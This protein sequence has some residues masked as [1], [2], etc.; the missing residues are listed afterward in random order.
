MDK[1]RKVL[2]NT[3]GGRLVGMEGGDPLLP[4]SPGHHN[5]IN[6]HSST[7]PPFPH[8][9]RSPSPSCFHTSN[10]DPVYLLRFLKVFHFYISHNSRRRE[11]KHLILGYHLFLC[12]AWFLSSWFD[13][14]TA[15]VTMHRHLGTKAVGP[16]QF[17]FLRVHPPGQWVIK[18]SA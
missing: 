2:N 4:D 12:F 18:R 11:R 5:S 8:R 15:I 7:S 14:F 17:N 3:I 6:K 9:C 10:F 16:S 13:D 1:S